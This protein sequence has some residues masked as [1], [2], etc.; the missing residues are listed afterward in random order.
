MSVG[1]VGVA[2]QPVGVGQNRCTERT[3][4]LTE[5]ASAGDEHEIEMTG[6]G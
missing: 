2:H 3:L 1:V 4:R 5:H 6:I